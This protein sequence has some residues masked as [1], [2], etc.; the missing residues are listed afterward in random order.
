MLHSILVHDLL[1]IETEIL[2]FK[3]I[4]AMNLNFNV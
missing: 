1:A 2:F 4:I 3:V